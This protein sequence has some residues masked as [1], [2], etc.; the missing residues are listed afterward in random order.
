MPNEQ[1]TQLGEMEARLATLE[2]KFN[3]LVI[4]LAHLAD[5]VHPNRATDSEGLNASTSVNLITQT[6]DPR[7][8]EPLGF[9]RSLGNL[10]PTELINVVGLAKILGR[11]KK[12][13]E[14]AIRRGE[15]PPPIKMM[16][17]HTWSVQQLND[18]FQKRIDHV[19]KLEQRRQA[20]RDAQ[21]P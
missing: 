4:A 12:S 11:C 3:R 15:L 7:S 1:A 13:I 10:P 18:H 5:S 6:P 19:T 17:R 2:G 8:V 21:W 16:G 20:R 9:P 14:R